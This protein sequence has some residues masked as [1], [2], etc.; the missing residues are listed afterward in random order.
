[1]V[2]L[3]NDSFLS[4][5]TR[6]F[7]ASKTGGPLSITMKKYDGRN[8]PRAARETTAAPS[9]QKCLLRA[10][11]SKKKISTVVIQKDVNKFQQAYANLLKGNIDG[12]KKRER[13]VKTKVAM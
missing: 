13:K 3:D 2:L 10:T 1:M 9:E 5:L 12:L 6:M 4:E 7:Q 11:N 8:K